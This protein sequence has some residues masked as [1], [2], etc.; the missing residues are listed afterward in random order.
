MTKLEGRRR[1]T[2]PE[3]QIS[4]LGSLLFGSL[5]TRLPRFHLKFILSATSRVNEKMEQ[6][7]KFTP[8]I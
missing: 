4:F 7:A 2:S 6:E 3:I 5:E 8:L 1:V